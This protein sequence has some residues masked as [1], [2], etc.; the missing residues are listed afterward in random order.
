MLNNSQKSACLR[1]ELAATVDWGEPFVKACY[2]LEGDGPLAV[3]CYEATERILAGLRTEYIPNVRAIA[4]LLSGKPPNDQS[5]EAW[6]SYARACVQPGLDYFQRQVDTSL[7]GSLDVFKGCRLFSPQKIHIMQPSASTIDTD[8]KKIPF[9]N[10][11]QELNGLKEELPTY[12]ARAADTDENFDILEWW[13]RNSSH[14]PY[15]SA[16]AKRIFL[17]QPSSAASERVF[18]LLK[19]SFG[20]QQDNALQDY[21]EASLMLQYNKR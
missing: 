20:D 3:D 11:V 12:L 19:N 14:L 16:A 18:S 2:Y 5:H 21:V 7:R 15:W 9:L 1:I 6:V 17:V 10:T 13:K 8:L 4:Q